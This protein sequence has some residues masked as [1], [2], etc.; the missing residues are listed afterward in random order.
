[1]LAATHLMFAKDQRG[2]WGAPPGPKGPPLPLSLKKLYRLEMIFWTLGM[3][4]TTW[5]K[6]WSYIDDLHKK[7]S[8]KHKIIIIKIGDK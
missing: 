3:M 6:H 4:R 5:L 8:L 2:A 1:M 7:K